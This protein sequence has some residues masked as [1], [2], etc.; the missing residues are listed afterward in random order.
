MVSTVTVTNTNTDT[1]VVAGGDKCYNGNCRNCTPASLV[2]RGCAFQIVDEGIDLNAT[3]ITGNAELIHTNT[4]THYLRAFPVLRER[5]YIYLPYCSADSSPY[6]SD[7]LEYDILGK[8]SKYLNIGS[9]ISERVASDCV[10]AALI[11]DRKLFV[12]DSAIFGS[13]NAVTAYIMDFAAE[14]VTE[15]LTEDNDDGE[16]WLRHLCTVKDMVGDIH[17]VGICQI[18]STPPAQYCGMKV[19]HKNY[20]QSGAWSSVTV[21]ADDEGG[22]IAES[23]NCEWFEI[24]NNRYVVMFTRIHYDGAW[25]QGGSI[26]VY[27]IVTETMDY[28]SVD[29]GSWDFTPEFAFMSVDHTNN[30]CYLF[31]DYYH[32]A[33]DGLHIIEFDPADMSYS[34]VFTSGIYTS[35]LFTFTSNTHSYFW[36]DED[37]SFYQSSNQNML[38]NYTLPHSNSSHEKICF[39]LDDGDGLSGELLWFFNTTNKHLYSIDMGGDV[40]VNLDLSSLTLLNYAHLFHLGNCLLLALY[41]NTSPYRFEYYLIT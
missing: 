10:S 38:F 28:V 4:R 13:D 17:L 21:Y 34:T 37:D 23:I 20:T 36:D 32:T 27:D 9:G 16:I 8:T 14:T 5:Q 24:V 25:G 12:T 40:V 15:E 6:S 31:G 1:T 30:K 35:T 11:E 18:N 29:F 41:K 22:N 39:V 2:S 3:G 26:F 7:I 19:W 33:G